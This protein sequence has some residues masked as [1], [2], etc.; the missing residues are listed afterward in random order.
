MSTTQSPIAFAV[1]SVELATCGV[2]TTLSSA[3]QRRRHV[4]LVVKH[5][6][7]GSTEL[8]R[9]QRLDQRRLV[10]QPAA[11]DVDEDAARPQRLDDRLIDDRPPRS[12]RRAGGAQEQDVAVPR[13]RDGVGI[14]AVGDVARRRV[15]IAYLAS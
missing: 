5:V 12:L 3:Q 14:G 4:R 2:S 6:E 10:D 11:R 7:P 9:R 15:D 8:S 13:Q 1:S